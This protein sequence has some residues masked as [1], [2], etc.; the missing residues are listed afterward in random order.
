MCSAVCRIPT[1]RTLINL[2]LRRAHTLTQHLSRVPWNLFD[3]A[4]VL[5][6][7][8]AFIPMSGKGGSTAGVRALRALRALRPLST[9]IRF[10]ALRSIVVCFLEVKGHWEK[11]DEGLS[12]MGAA[13][14]VS[15]GCHSCMPAALVT[16]ALRACALLPCRRYPCWPAWSACCTSS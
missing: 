6:G 7:Y 13:A 12:G 8:T 16:A 10:E 3:C 14:G 15:I 5:A 1:P 4:M 2:P 11:Q 9:I